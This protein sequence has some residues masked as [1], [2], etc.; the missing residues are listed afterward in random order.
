MILHNALLR[1]H[2]WPPYPPYKKTQKKKIIWNN[3]K[4]KM[5][6]LVDDVNWREEVCLWYVQQKSVFLPMDSDLLYKNEK[7]K[8]KMKK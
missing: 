3:K 7:E 6:E 4:R 8:R 1:K 2:L 5:I